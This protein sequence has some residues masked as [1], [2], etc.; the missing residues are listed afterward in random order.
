M[1]V[2]EQTGEELGLP[3]AKEDAQQAAVVKVNGS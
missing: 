3:S 1:L 2:K